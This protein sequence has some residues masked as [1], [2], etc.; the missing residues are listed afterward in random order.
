MDVA[1][2]AKLPYSTV[3]DLFKNGS[4]HVVTID[5]VTQAL[6]VPYEEVVLT[7]GERSA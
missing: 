2:N 7:E 4:G 1:R 5:A 6:G 3:R